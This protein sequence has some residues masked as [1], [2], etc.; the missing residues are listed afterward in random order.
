[1]QRLW[2]LVQAKMHEANLGCLQAVSSRWPTTRPGVAIAAHFDLSHQLQSMQTADAGCGGFTTLNRQLSTGQQ[3]GYWSTKWV[4]VNKSA[5][6]V[7][8]SQHK[9]QLVNRSG[10]WSTKVATGQHKWLLVLGNRRL[11]PG[12][13]NGVHAVGQLG[14][15]NGG[16]GVSLPRLLGGHLTGDV[17]ADIVCDATVHIL[18]HLCNASTMQ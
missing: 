5:T 7:M 13:R 12:S 4:L 17:N 11:R 18:A 9:C 10:Y 16:G 3:N 1:M 2:I 6:K 8:T 14:E 15:G